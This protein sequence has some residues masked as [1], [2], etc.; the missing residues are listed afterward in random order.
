MTKT[1]KKNV[2][3]INVHTVSLPSLCF[4]LFWTILLVGK[5]L[6]YSSADMVFRNMTLFGLLFCMAK[7]LLTKWNNTEIMTA[8][9]LF[10]MG[11]LVWYFSNE[12]DVLLTILVIISMKN[13]DILKCMK[14]SFWVKLIFFLTETTWRI[15]GGGDM[16]PMYRWENGIPTLRYGLGY[17]HPNATHYT[18]FVIFV[19]GIIAY[20]KKLKWFHYLFMIIYNMF[21]F[22]YT[23]SRTGWILS[24]S[25]LLLSWG[26]NGRKGE[27]ARKMLRYLADKAYIVGTLI[28]FLISYSVLFL[29]KLVNLGTISSRFKSGAV[30]ISQW[31]LSLFGTTGI[32]S[33]FGYMEI[34]Y[35]KGIIVFVLFIYSMTKILKQSVRKGWWHCVAVLIVYSVYTLMESYTASVLMN[36]SL[37][38]CSMLIFKNMQEKIE[39]N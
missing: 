16:Q 27:L 1:F 39:L 24:L 5:G 38:L 12:I 9:L 34:L 28:S 23:D 8:F 35:Q 26:L 37:L 25:V 2:R 32:V 7:L 11:V 30:M 20:G 36:I 13:I 18:L 31:N 4:Y 15:Y 17:G 19:L 14:W 29:S 6:G 3:K 22:E 21:I 33:D 10:F